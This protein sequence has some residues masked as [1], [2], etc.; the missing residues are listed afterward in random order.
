MSQSEEISS[1][2]T[3]S[4]HVDDVVICILKLFTENVIMFLLQTSREHV[5][6]Y[7]LKLK[8]QDQTGS[9]QSQHSLKRDTIRTWLY[10]GQFH[11]A[12]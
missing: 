1:T 3:Y 12:A 2:W 9:F 7:S 8:R 5:G 10:K 11:R 6:L 4:V